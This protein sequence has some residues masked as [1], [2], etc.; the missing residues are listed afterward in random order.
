M[1]HSI[2]MDRDHEP[3]EEDLK[4]ALGDSYALWTEIREHVRQRYPDGKEEWNFPGKNSG[5]SGEKHFPPSGKVKSLPGSSQTWN[6][7]G[8][9]QKD[10]EFG[11]PYL[12]GPFSGT[13]L[14]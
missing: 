1:D 13:F 10:A 14:P 8:C 11:F 6:L 9:M 2:F 4:L 12:T 7:P 3:T 5:F